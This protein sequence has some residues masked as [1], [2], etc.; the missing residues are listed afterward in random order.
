[1]AAADVM[2][3]VFTHEVEREHVEEDVANVLMG[4]SACDDRPTV[5]G[6]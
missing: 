5:A 6:T 2:E 3:E 4:E 1:V